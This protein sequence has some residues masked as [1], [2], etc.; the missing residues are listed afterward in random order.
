MNTADVTPIFVIRPYNYTLFFALNN[1]SV[2][3]RTTLLVVLTIVFLLGAFGNSATFLIMISRR[4]RRLSYANYLIALSVS[5]FVVCLNATLMPVLQFAIVRLSDARYFVIN[6]PIGCGINE[7]FMASMSACSSWLLVAISLERA[8]VVLFPFASRLLCTPRFARCAVVCIFVFNAFAIGGY[9]G[10]T[11]KF[12][13]HFFGCYYQIYDESV[14]Y[15]SYVVYVYIV[16]LVLIMTSNSVIIVRLFT[17]SKMVACDRKTTKSKRTT[18]M[19]VT[20]SIAFA[21]FIFPS[22]FAAFLPNSTENLEFI[23]DMFTH[24]LMF[25]YVIA[26]FGL[27]NEFNDK[28]MLKT[29]CGSPLCAS[30][31]S[32]RTAVQRTGGTLV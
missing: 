3:Y 5:D 28:D 17:G 32:Q 18:V 31:E 27:S 21:I 23:F 2:V 1:R 14:Y 26:D 19:L 8:A 7:F 30:P 24:F 6:S 15:I 29:Y 20:V 10:L 11:V 12:S 4:F 13:D 9:P 22:S 16:P 25:N